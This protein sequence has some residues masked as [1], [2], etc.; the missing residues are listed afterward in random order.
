VSAELIAAIAAAV[1][2]TF[3][4]GV[5][6]AADAVAT[7]VATRAA[8][9]GPAL[10]MT[11]LCT[12]VGP[13]LLGAAVAGTVEDLLDLPDAMAVA[14]IGGALTGA[15]VWN[16]ASWRLGLPS[17]STHALVGGLVGAALVAHG[18]DAVSWSTLGF[19][20][21]GLVASPLLGFLVGLAGQRAASRSLRRA[22]TRVREPVMLAQWLG[23][24]ALSV[25]HGANDAA[26]AAGVIV[27]LLVATGHASSSAAPLWVT[28]LAAG[29]LTFGTAAGGWQ[30]VR[31]VGMSI[32]RLRMLDGFV[33]QTGSS[34]LVLGASAVGAPVSTSQVVASSVAGVGSGRRWHHVNW[35]S[36][37]D[38]AVAWLL[39]LPACAALG[40][41]AYPVWEWL[42]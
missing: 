40:A 9:P 22:T 29:A 2:F 7:L 31:T 10:L 35:L 27:V 16:V 36:I 8:R 42:A 24:A 34:L 39:T 20:L 11:V 17:S 6:D 3:S 12:M 21:V 37:R 33:S 5:H 1:V 4:S 15:V 32:Y 18:T 25:G 19:V 13:L 30:I 26:K 38:I 41:L 14:V 28:L 23:S